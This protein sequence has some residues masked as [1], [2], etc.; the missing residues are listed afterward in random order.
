MSSFASLVR[1]C[2]YARVKTTRTPAEK[3][4]EGQPCNI[5]FYSAS[6]VLYSHGH[7]FLKKTTRILHFFVLYRIEFG[8]VKSS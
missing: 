8:Q 4:W 3:F 5:E 2:V 7:T 1:R 6:Q